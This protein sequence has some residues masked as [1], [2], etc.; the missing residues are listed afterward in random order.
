[1]TPNLL[2]MEVHK[3]RVTINTAD[4][5][6]VVIHQGD[7]H[8]AAWELLDIGEALAASETFN[9]IE[10]GIGNAWV[11]I[12]SYDEVYRRERRALRSAKSERRLR[13][14]LASTPPAPEQPGV[15]RRALTRAAAMVW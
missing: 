14:Q 7:T 10:A 5:Y 6:R 12:V 9:A 3:G 11:E 1:M 2:D 4:L 8:E 13:A 15:F